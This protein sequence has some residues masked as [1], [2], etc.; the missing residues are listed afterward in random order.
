M[1]LGFVMNGVVV[2]HFVS[3]EHSPILRALPRIGEAL[4]G[5]GVPDGSA[6]ALG[7]Q[8]QV[9]TWGHENI[10]AVVSTGDSDA[11]DIDD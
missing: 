5:L 4:L 11:E 8:G 1:G 2:P 7:P 10:T 9:E 6:L 3:T